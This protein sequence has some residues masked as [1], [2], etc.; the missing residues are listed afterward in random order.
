MERYQ[1]PRNIAILLPTYNGESYLSD[2]IDSIIGQTYQ[3]FTLF[4]RDD[5]SIDKSV[6]IAQKYAEDKKNVVI[7]PFEKNYG[8][9]YSFLAMMEMIDSEYY[10]FCDQ[11]DIW[12]PT[13]VEDTYNKM[14]E[15]ETVY[16]HIPIV[17]HT[18]LRVV[19]GN[20]NLI[21]ESFW[22]YRGFDVYL[23]HSFPYLCHFNDVTGC[24]MM[25]NKLTQESCR[26]ILDFQF[27]DFMYYDNMVCILAV[28]ADGIVIPLNKQTVIYRR[29]GDNETDALKFGKSVFSRLNKI[30]EYICSQ[31]Q[32]HAFFKQFG[33]GS[34]AKFMY[35]KVKLYIIRKWKKQQD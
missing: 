16:P 22:K 28:K 21:S 18:D 5:G 2:L 4:I 14:L 24:T 10:M 26:G 30:G 13:K 15:S 9:R 33:Y 3:G 27:P 11:D 25:I 32:R 35:Y 20:L 6:D 31:R 19:D 8:A 12:M 17:I 1:N 7:I 23:P 34:F 29:H